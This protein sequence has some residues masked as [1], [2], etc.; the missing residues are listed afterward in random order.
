VVARRGFGRD[1]RRPR[2]TAHRAAGVRW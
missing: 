1:A 2:I